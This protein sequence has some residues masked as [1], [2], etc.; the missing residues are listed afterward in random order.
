WRYPVSLVVEHAMAH[1][2]TGPHP[3]VAKARAA[4]CEV[5]ADSELLGRTQREAGFV[6][7]VSRRAASP[8][9]DLFAHVFKVSGRE[10][11]VGGDPARPLLRL[12]PL[13]LGGIYV[14]DMPPARAE[15]T[16]S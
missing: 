14:L 10:T 13:E 1:G 6:A 7:I 4:G 8:A 15:L 5:I 9:L 11:E 2:Q 12:Y 3:L 16:L